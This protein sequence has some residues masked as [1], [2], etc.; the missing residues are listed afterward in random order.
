[1]YQFDK[2]FAYSAVGNGDLARLY[3]SLGDDTFVG[4]PQDSYFTGVYGDG[5]YHRVLRFDTVKA[6]SGGDG[7]DSA[8]LYDSPGDDTFHGYVDRGVLEGVDYLIEAWDFSAGSAIADPAHEDE[9]T[10]ILDPGTVGQAVGA[11]EI[12]L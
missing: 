1:M 7:A 9:D 10:A 12:E 4:R 8:T 6:Y 3:G 11:W 5:F 2:V